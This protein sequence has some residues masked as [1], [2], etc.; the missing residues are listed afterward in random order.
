MK[1]TR[2]KGWFIFERS[3]GALVLKYK[4]ETT[5]R[6]RDKRV[7]VSEARNKREAERWGAEWLST[8]RDEEKRTDSELTV[9][10]YL[11]RALERQSP[12]LRDTTRRNK[13]GHVKRHLVPALGRV[14]LAELTPKI[15]GEFV[16]EF[17]TRPRSDKEDAEPHAAHTV[18]NVVATLR[19]LLDDA[20]DLGLLASNPARSKLVRKQVP[21]AETLAAKRLG[22]EATV[23][24]AAVDLAKLLE[25]PLVP[26]DRKVRWLVS[27]TTGLR[28][29]ETSALRWCDVHLDAEVPHAGVTRALSTMRAKGDRSASE[30]AFTP[31]KTR[32]GSRR[33]PLCTLAVHA[34]R[35][36][37]AVLGD[38]GD[39]SP[40]FPGPNGKHY[41]P[42]S[43][44][45]LRADLREAGLP[46]NFR[47][48][49]IT[50]HALRRGFATEL[51]RTGAPE[52]HRKRLMGH[53]GGSVTEVHY[54]ARE[55]G[56]L[57]ESVARLSPKV[58]LEQMLRTVMGTVS[59]GADLGARPH[60]A[61]PRQS[62]DRGGFSGRR[63]S[64]S[65]RRVTVLQTVA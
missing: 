60:Q 52:A 64:D 65:N 14:L 40:L 53:S 13:S 15:V 1:T 21:A 25:C 45:L 31:P 19:D 32:H 4:D 28:D 34:L 59:L 63:G 8:G 35:E 3:D 2:R 50:A 42:E 11:E 57:A 24:V 37:R 10:A 62:K 9:G 36:W 54:T 18:R 27:F 55:L 39:E 7:P 6:W 12:E 26:F 5:E 41:R 43:A 49:P 51:A 17:R 23:H 22:T 48:E 56:E 30:L 58:T 47:G 20:V 44:E 38:A 61:A 33:V 29:G 16:T 46:D